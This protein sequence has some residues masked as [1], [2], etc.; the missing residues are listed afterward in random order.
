MRRREL[1]ILAVVLSLVAGCAA[2][3]DAPRIQQSLTERVVYEAYELRALLTGPRVLFFPVILLLGFGLSRALRVG[4]RALWRLGVDPA[5]R[6]AGHAAL[7]NFVIGAL[8]V[9]AMAARMVTVAPVLALVGLGLAVGAITVAL[10]EQIQDIAVGLALVARRR[11]REGDRVHI[12]E[13][14]GT[15]R[16]VGLTRVELRRSDGTAIHVPTRLLG[17][18]ALVIGHA[19]HTV[20]V[21]AQIEIA[22]DRAA[23][24]GEIALRTALCSPYRALGSPVEVRSDPGGRL[25][26]EIQAWSEH[27]ARDARTQLELALSRELGAGS[28]R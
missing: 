15:V 13:H 4:M 14:A 5:H 21:S 10:R 16:K 3:G 22:A 6:L 17:A 24:A 7:W 18:S 12:G 20:P 2:A 11:L 19:R 8:V 26:V 1:L 25:H 9:W 23:R 27:A 28:R